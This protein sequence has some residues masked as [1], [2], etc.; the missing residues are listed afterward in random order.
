[1]RY[2]QVERL[3][4]VL[5]KMRLT[6]IVRIGEREYMHAGDVFVGQSATQRDC[7]RVFLAMSGQKPVVR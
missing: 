3:T 1:M 4:H 6:K 5:V 7:I 2:K